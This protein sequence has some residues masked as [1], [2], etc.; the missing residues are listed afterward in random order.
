M[1]GHTCGKQY[2]HEELLSDT[3]TCTS[4]NDNSWSSSNIEGNLVGFFSDGNRIA[5]CENRRMGKLVGEM[6]MVVPY[7]SDHCHLNCTAAQRNEHA[8][9]PHHD[10]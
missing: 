7:A 3:T 10:Q 1:H 8:Y 5:F 2:V 6:Q 9:M 4:F